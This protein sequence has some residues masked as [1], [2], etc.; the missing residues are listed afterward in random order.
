[1]LHAGKR[2]NNSHQADSDM[3]PT[4]LPAKNQATMMHS[5]EPSRRLLRQMVEFDLQ[6]IKHKIP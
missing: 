2:I 4:W 1:M 6:N 5:Q 3:L